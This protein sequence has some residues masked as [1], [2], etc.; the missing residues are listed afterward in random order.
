MKRLSDLNP[1]TASL[2][3]FAVTG[4]AMFCSDPRL[5]VISLAGS[6][7]FFLVRNRTAHAEMHLY[8]AGIFL[9][10]ALINPLV[11]HN[12]V[13]VL[14]VLNH[15]PITLEAVLYGLH[16]AAMVVSVLYWF[17]AFT[18]IMTSEKLLYL[19]GALSPRLSLVLSMALRFVPLFRRQA[20][21][22]SNAQRAL[23]LYRNDNAIDTLRGKLRE[24]S[25][26]VTWALEN[27]IITADSMET[28]G[29]GIG[30]RSQL[31]QF[32]FTRQDGIVLAVTLVLAG[33]T[34]VS[35]GTGRLSFTFY[36]AMSAAAPGIPG[37][38]GI[39]AYA[40]LVLLPAVMELEVNLRWKF[41]RSRI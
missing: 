9:V 14:F 11:S 38:C 27:G 36:P 19:T 32:R 37:L 5:I 7:V 22:I 39:A 10:L 17:Y 31:R 6:V 28:R 20:E 2:W 34:A 30:R 21:K 29:Y 3:F 16:A 1:I 24:F 4:I 40:A 15:N 33:I 41:L 26:L 35:V 13:T 8:F 18:Q 12:G 25:I 23:G